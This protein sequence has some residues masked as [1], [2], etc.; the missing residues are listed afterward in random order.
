MSKITFTSEKREGLFGDWS[1]SVKVGEQQYVCS[2][3]RGKSVRIP[4]HKKRGWQ[5]HGSVYQYGGGCLFA[6]RV[7]G[8][9]GCRG[10]LIEAG[11]IAEAGESEQ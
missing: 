1:R 9:I 4:Y 10:L 6:G 7:P 11:V 2:V 5:W 3:R 8:S